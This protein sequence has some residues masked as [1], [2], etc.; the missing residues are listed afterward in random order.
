MKPGILT[1]IVFQHAGD[2]SRLNTLANDN[3]LGIH[4]FGCRCLSCK[5]CT[6]KAILLPGKEWSQEIKA[7]IHVADVQNGTRDYNLQVLT[8]NCIIM[9][10]EIIENQHQSL[11]IWDD[12]G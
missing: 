5:Q 1:G 7:F 9:G 4:G 10:L 3:G 11:S 12:E 8:Y 2:G 6:S